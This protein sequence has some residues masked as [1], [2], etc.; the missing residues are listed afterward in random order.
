MNALFD[1]STASAVE[2]FDY[3]TAGAVEMLFSFDSILAFSI[4]LLETI[5]VAYGIYLL[6][7]E[8]TTVGSIPTIDK[9]NKSSNRN[10]NKFNK[11]K[12]FQDAN[13]SK[14]IIKLKILKLEV[15]SLRI[16]MKLNNFTKNVNSFLLNLLSHN[17]FSNSRKLT[18]KNDFIHVNKSSLRR[19]RVNAR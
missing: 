1:Y 19:Q 7:K 17:K 13:S 15:F 16:I 18:I 10:D 2:I 14:R 12:F 6:N 5:F 8:L 11:V 4:I 3:S 9:L